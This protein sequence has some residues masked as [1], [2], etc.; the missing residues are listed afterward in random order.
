M[1]PRFT[2]F[3]DENEVDLGQVKDIIMTHLTNLQSNSLTQFPE[4]PE[5]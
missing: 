4:F 3:V 1:F 5:N 2:Q